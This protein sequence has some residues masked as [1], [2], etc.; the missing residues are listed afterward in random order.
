M[1]IELA[2]VA[3]F[4]GQVCFGRSDIT[5]AILNKV[6]VFGVNET[7]INETIVL[8][9]VRDLYTMAGGGLQIVDGVSTY[10]IENGQIQGV[11]GHGLIIPQ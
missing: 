1:D 9:L 7:L 10:L 8:N 6:E 11:T 3:I 2:A 5:N 4:F